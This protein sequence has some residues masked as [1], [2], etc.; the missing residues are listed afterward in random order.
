M[1]VP[2]AKV[3]GRV[4][5]RLKD[6]DSS[7]P[8][9]S[10]PDVD[11]AIAEAWIA[12]NAFLPPP[13]L[14]VASAFTISAGASTFT[15]PVTVASSGYGT[16]TT[17]YGG[18]VQI[19]LVTSGMYLKEITNGEMDAL[20]D[21]TPTVPQALPNQFALYQDNSQVIKGRCYPGASVAQACNL[22]A[23][24]S[25]EDL[26]DYVGTGG[27]E[28]MDTVTVPGTRK[29]V[30]ALVAR[31]SWMLLNG[32]PTDAAAARGIDKNA[33]VQEWREEEDRLAYQEEKTQHDIKSTGRVQRRVA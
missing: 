17:E 3:R 25:A 10:G 6:A 4:R 24:I 7:K 14:Y 9:F 27:A 11:M 28:G 1:S 30:Q 23:T 21:G 18:N 13:L 12:L 22:W 16:G 26:R 8:A 2:I 29:A 19:Q 32:E 5:I 31:A 33:K 15:L 20:L